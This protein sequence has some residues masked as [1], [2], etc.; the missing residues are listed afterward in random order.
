M[1][2][3]YM[4][5]G[6]GYQEAMK[7]AAVVVLLLAICYSFA[8]ADIKKNNPPA[9]FTAI[10]TSSSVMTYT[11]FMMT[12]WALNT[13]RYEETN[14][15]ARFYGKNN[16]VSLA[17]TFGLDLGIIFAQRE[18][19]KANK[20]AGWVFLIATTAARAYVVIRNLKTIEKIERGK[21]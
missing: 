18:I 9:L 19:Y 4:C 20:T 8:L 14:P 2:Y 12:S 13:G 10:Q 15:I 1:I 11:D 7:R 6:C 16:G 3:D 21:Q 17:V 5:R